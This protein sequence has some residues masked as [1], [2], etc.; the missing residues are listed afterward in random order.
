MANSDQRVTY[1]TGSCQLESE[2]LSGLGDLLH[3]PELEGTVIKCLMTSGLFSHKHPRRQ[4]MPAFYKLILT[5][6]S[7]LATST[8]FY[9]LEWEAV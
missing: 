7:S 9:T 4:I 2:E 6:P 5:L 3:L 8:M 1:Q